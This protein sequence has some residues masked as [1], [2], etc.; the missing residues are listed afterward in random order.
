LPVANGTISR[1]ALVAGTM[2]LLEKNES[3]F[4]QSPQEWA[5]ERFTQVQAVN[6][7]STWAVRAAEW[8]TFLAS[9]L[10]N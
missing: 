3:L 2:A 8:E 7:L 9:Q 10:R 6:R 1:D 4:L 5:Q